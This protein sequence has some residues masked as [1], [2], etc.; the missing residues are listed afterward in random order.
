MQRILEPELMDDLE[1]ARAYHNADFSES[2]G[3]RVNL[4]RDR[5][6][7]THFRGKVLDL[8]CG[9]GDII[10]RFA[11]AFDQ[12]QF[13]AVDGSEAML[14]I[15]RNELRKNSTLLP[16]VEFV[17]AF[18]PS[19]SIPVDDYK[20]IMSHSFLHHLHNP[21]VLWTTIK[22]FARPNTFIFVADLKRPPSLE[23]AKQIIE[24]QAAGEPEV[25]RL[26]FY[27]SLCA[28]FTLDEISDQLT[29]AGLDHL[30]VESVGDNHV[31][32]YGMARKKIINRPT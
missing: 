23:A 24:E 25:L 28:A 10:F 22:Q 6:P 1:Q 13:A 9:S 26:D 12:L 15:A 7:S 31:L 8:G 32:I 3:Q 14:S 5:L 11:K 21:L 16:R 20:V 27:N 2:H 19:D 18:I 30:T 29:T 17:E 4:F